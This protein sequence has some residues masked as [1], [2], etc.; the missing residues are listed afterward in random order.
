ME[1]IKINN[2]HQ[3][4]HYGVYVNGILFNWLT[5][6]YDDNK[7]EERKKLWKDIEN[8]GDNLQ[9]PW[10]IMGDFNNVLSTTDR[11]GGRPV[12]EYEYTDQSRMIGKNGRFE[13]ESKGVKYI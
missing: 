1:V 6:V 12:K 3:M 4:V 2:T 7:L 5:V 13:V 8:I 9:G 10:S 11:V